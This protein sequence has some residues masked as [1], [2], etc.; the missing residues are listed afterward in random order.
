MKY[1]FIGAGNIATAL[2]HG[3]VKSGKVDPTDIIIYNK[4]TT[5]QEKIVELTGVIGFSRGEDVATSADVL[6][7]AVKPNVLVDLLPAYNEVLT[8]S[9]KPPVIVS[10]AAGVELSLLT[11][12]LEDKTLPIVRAMPNLN[13]YVGEGISAYCGNENA[14][15]W[16]KDI[17]ANF[18]KSSGKAL[19]LEEK[20]FGTF[21]A[22]AGSSPA[23]GYLFID[24]IAKAAHKHGM[25]KQD[26]LKIAAQ[27]IL[28][29][30][31]MLL[32]SDEHPAALIDKV[33]SPGGMTIEGIVSLQDRA[34][35]STVVRS[36]EAVINKNNH[37][38]TK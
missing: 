9:S 31:K 25:K 17:V 34:F 5:V 27:A 24:S 6:F 26:A 32:E 3:A 8:E 36:L 29:S 38:L 15:G 30:A 14:L 1:G 4:N 19:E 11:K 37:L 28:G 23:F 18:L 20:H 13:S 2:I 35:E 22:L 33:C 7:F 21:A 10:V 12:L 16:H